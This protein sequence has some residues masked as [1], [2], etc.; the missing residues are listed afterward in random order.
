MSPRR[1][2][3]ARRPLGEVAEVETAAVV[4]VV[5]V[6]VVMVV[7]VEEEGI[8]DT[9]DCCFLEDVEDGFLGDLDLGLG[10]GLDLG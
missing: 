10:L 4:V 2:R 3:F 7:V 9:V 5:V 1:N 8:V 6:V